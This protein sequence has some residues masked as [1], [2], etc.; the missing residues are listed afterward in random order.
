MDRMTLDEWNAL[1]PE[2]QAEMPDLMPEELAS[3]PKGE[4][5]KSEDDETD[6]KGVP[7]KNRLA[8][9]NRKLEVISKKN[10]ELEM[11]LNEI[12]GQISKGGAGKKTVDDL[13]EKLRDTGFDDSVIDGIVSVVQE[14]SGKG[15][16]EIMAEIQALRV[17]NARIARENIL[18]STPDEFGIIAK[19]RKEIDAELDSYDPTLT[20]N[21]EIVNIAISRVVMRHLKDLLVPGKSPE[22]TPGEPKPEGGGTPPPTGLEAEAQEYARETGIDVKRA[23]QIVARKHAAEEKLNK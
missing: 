23:R 21:P 11:K 4:Q 16:K 19:F 2:E 12:S 17:E 15:R 5:G 6:D 3:P 18:K 14:E 13:R 7:L 20:G 1:T 22:G 10:A 8:E 9:A